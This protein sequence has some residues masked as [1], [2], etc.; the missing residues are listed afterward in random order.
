M[1]LDRSGGQAPLV[2]LGKPRV[3]GLVIVSSGGWSFS[4]DLAES[5]DISRPGEQL[6]CSS[7]RS[8]SACSFSKVLFP[9]SSVTSLEQSQEKAAAGR[10]GRTIKEPLQ[11]AQA[12]YLRKAEGSLRKG[13]ERRKPKHSGR[14]GRHTEGNSSTPKV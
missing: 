13:P 8:G 11:R 7:G 2:L 10:R 12:F 4:E 9:S 1:T 6:F 14:R 5:W 3:T